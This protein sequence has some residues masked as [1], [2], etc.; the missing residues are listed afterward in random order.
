MSELQGFK[1]PSCSYDES[2]SVLAP[3]TFN[4]GKSGMVGGGN[5][6]IYP[7]TDVRCQKC[8]CVSS[9]ISFCP[10]RWLDRDAKDEIY[11]SAE[12]LRWKYDHLGDGG[13][14]DHP[15]YP[16]S[17]WAVEAGE[18]E[19]RLGYWEWVAHQIELNEEWESEHDEEEI[20]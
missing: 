7:H 13:W 10:Q 17:A 8:G 15:V 12:A 18:I 20:A 16:K 4:V 19:T 9:A 3:M 2:I 5:L 14:G 1:C 6:E 11:L